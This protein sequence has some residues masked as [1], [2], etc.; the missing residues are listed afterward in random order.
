MLGSGL[1]LS[2]LADALGA[3][4]SYSY[5][6]I[7]GFPAPTVP[8]HSG[9]MVYGV[10]SGFGVALFLGRKHIYEG[11]VDDAV[12]VPALMGRLCAKVGFFTSSVGAVC[13][14][15][16]PGELVAITDI[17]NL[18]GRYAA[19][20][21]FPPRGRV[22][23]AFDGE[24]TRLLLESGAE[25]GVCLRRGVLAAVTGPSYETPAEV[26]MLRTIGASVVS[27]SMAPELSAAYGAGI[28]CVGVSVVTNR[29][30]ARSE[31]AEVLAA[32]KEAS[33]RLLRVAR[34]FLE[35]YSA[36]RRDETFSP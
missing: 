29:A 18:Q 7:P 24:L 23:R 20:Y 12:F 35:K 27:M 34:R 6:E 25:I 19:R 9:R 36:L 1:D 16:S 11:S 31:H 5:G 8:G 13:E 14:E 15:L 3:V 17:V 10:F 4:R 30:G 22:Y 21:A 26:R 2:P 28:R 32:A 33:Q